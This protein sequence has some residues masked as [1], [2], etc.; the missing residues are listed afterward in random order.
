VLNVGVLQVLKGRLADLYS[1]WSNPSN[2][3]CQG[4]TAATGME[5]CDP[6]DPETWLPQNLRSWDHAT[7]AEVAAEIFGSASCFFKNSLEDPNIW[8]KHLHPDERARYDWSSNPNAAFLAKESSLFHTHKPVVSYLEDE[9]GEPMQNGTVSMAV[10]CAGLLGNIFFTLPLT[11]SSGIPTTMQDSSSYSPFTQSSTAN[12]T[13]LQEYIVKISR[14][15]F[16]S[17]PLYRHYL[18]HHLATDSAGCPSVATEMEKGDSPDREEFY[19][20]T[21]SNPALT[22]KY[23]NTSIARLRRRGVSYGLLG[24]APRGRCFCG[25]AAAASASSNT[26]A[27]ANSSAAASTNTTADCMLPPNILYDLLLLSS[28]TSTLDGH[29]DLG[30][31]VRE[32]AIKQGGSFSSLSDNLVLQRVLP[33]IWRRGTWECPELDPS[34]HWGVVR[35]TASWLRSTE[36]LELDEVDFLET[37]FGGIRVGT[38]PHILQEAKVK[39]TPAD[40]QGVFNPSDG[41]PV[42]GH[43]LCTSDI[44]SMRTENL[45]DH[46]VNNLFPAAQGVVDSAPVSYCMRYAIEL[47]RV[48]VLELLHADST[49]AA[50]VLANSWKKK[51]RTQ[52]QLLSMCV[53]TRALDSKNVYVRSPGSEPVMCPFRLRQDPT[54]TTLSETYG[55][56]SSLGYITPGCLLYAYPTSSSTS[57]LYDPCRHYPCS[58]QSSSSSQQRPR[59]VA[60]AQAAGF[61]VLTVLEVQQHSATTLLPFNPVKLVDR[62]EVN[63]GMGRWPTSVSTSSISQAEYQ[64]YLQDVMQRWYD[65]DFDTNDFP[66]GLASLE[67]DE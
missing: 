31:L 15:A 64:T 34:D 57:A 36:T 8:F 67:L 20:F 62:M 3:A 2:L 1:K 35:D 28:E 65:D 49:R 12:I 6:S 11:P 53:S 50:R 46:F 26:T 55:Y 5:F 63:H 54:R 48:V 38:L 9:L 56:E 33:G 32:V 37:G 19:S 16:Q 42:T 47:A 4:R 40:R 13:A 43:T 17:S 18:M 61:L 14:A 59:T 24:A 52:I 60:E 7:T 44:P 45:A 22:N 41:D 66:R 25:F 30:Y 58:Q 23:A 51:C 10:M 29:P 27:S 21:S 39:V